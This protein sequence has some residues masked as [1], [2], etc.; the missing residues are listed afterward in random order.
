MKSL[1]SFFRPEFLNRVDEVVIFDILSPE[2][3]RDIVKIRVMQVSKRILDQGITLELSDEALAY[4]GKEGY[5]PQMGA[6]P[7]HRLIQTKIL[8]HLLCL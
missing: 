4:L 7:L 6:R 3:I 1:Q 2:V 8:N 5:N